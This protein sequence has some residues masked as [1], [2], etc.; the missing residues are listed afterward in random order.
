VVM[1]QGMTFVTLKDWGSHS[2][3]AKD[4]RCLGCGA[5]SFGEWFLMFKRIVVSSPSL[6]RRRAMQ[7]KYCMFHGHGWCGYETAREG[8]EPA[9]NVVEVPSVNMGE[10]EC[11]PIKW[12]NSWD[13][14]GCIQA[15]LSASG[16]DQGRY[17]GQGSWS[18]ECIMVIKAK[19][20][21]MKY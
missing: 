5:F 21:K 17:M 14:G 12:W 19:W 18:L 2:G 15:V 13:R 8:G 11:Q 3:V 10:A 9:G 6:W 1:L 7:K 16:T 20:M 4:A